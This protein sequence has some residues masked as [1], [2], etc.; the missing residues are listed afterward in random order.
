MAALLF[1]L[2]LHPALAD[3][4]CRFDQA[5][6][7]PK[8]ALDHFT[9]RSHKTG[10]DLQFDIAV[11]RSGETFRFKVEADEQKGEGVVTS[12]LDGGRDPGIK[13]TF[14][15][16]DASG[17][18]AP[19]LGEVGSISFLDL[20]RAI[21]GFCLREGQQPDPYTSPPS[22]LWDLAECRAN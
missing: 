2:A 14:S 16:A 3:I 19:S 21:L 20:G 1:G 10:G 13:A 7:R 18:K 17:L 22:G 12:L 5:T 11:R 8:Y 4:A 9:L 15:L 6:F